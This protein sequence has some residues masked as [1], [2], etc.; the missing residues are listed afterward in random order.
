MTPYVI[1]PSIIILANKLRKLFSPIESVNLPKFERV[2]II[3]PIL[4]EEL[5][6]IK[7]FENLQN[8][9]FD[10]SILEIIFYLDGTTDNSEKKIIE[11][12]TLFPNLDVKILKN[13]ETYGREVAHNSSVKESKYNFLVFT[14]IETIFEK[15][16]LINIVTK[17]NDVDVGMVVGKLIFNS[18]EPV[19]KV[20]KFYF[21]LETYL[22]S[23]L[24]D[25]NLLMTGTGAAMAI[26]KELYEDL[27]P[28]EDIDD[29]LPFIVAKKNKKILFAENCIAYD[30][31]VSELESQF[32]SRSRMSSKGLTAFLYRWSAINSLKF[33]FLT[34]TFIFH[35]ICKWLTGLWLILIYAI[36]LYSMAI[37]SSTLSF[38]V[39]FSL[40]LCLLLCVLNIFFK[41]HLNSLERISSVIYAIFGALWGLVVALRKK[42]KHG[43]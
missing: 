24:S 36:S 20:E 21:G 31:P 35:K 42:T 16:F 12:K 10:K 43:Y 4:N 17:L 34:L 39:I 2:S 33:P 13:K 25:L 15:D 27:R 6:I 7:K 18:E 28:D 37:G 40:S 38:F 14:D 30:E 3:I 5:K 29:S 22:R 9:S 32:L 11:C 41:W 1:F 8:L 23:Q 19:G 26:K